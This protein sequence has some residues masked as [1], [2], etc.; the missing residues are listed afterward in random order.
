MVEQLRLAWVW[1]VWLQLAWWV[2]WLARLLPQLRIRMLGLW[3]RLGIWDWIRV[4]LGIRRSC[5]VESLLGLPL[6]VLLPILGLG[7]STGARFRRFSTAVFE[8]GPGLQQ[9]L[10]SLPKPAEA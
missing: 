4:G 1:L 10:S 5:L 3:L 2:L 6:P 7:S 9:F 8:L